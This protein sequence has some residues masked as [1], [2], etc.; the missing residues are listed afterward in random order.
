MSYVSL[1]E[2]EQVSIDMHRGKTATTPNAQELDSRLL[3][4]TLGEEETLDPRKT[5]VG[6]VV[7]LLNERELLTLRGIEATLNAVRL[8]ELLKR[9]DEELSVVLIRE[10]R[11]WD[12]RWRRTR[13]GSAK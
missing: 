2:G 3:E 12:G 1:K 9:E 8:F 11:E 6:V 5:L 4:G 7:R 13:S 10:R